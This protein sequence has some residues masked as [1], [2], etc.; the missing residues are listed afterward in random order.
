MTIN[1]MI[2]AIIFLFSILFFKRN[3][4]K[5]VI[6]TIITKGNN[7]SVTG[8]ICTFSE[9]IKIT[10]KIENRIGCMINGIFF[11]V[12]SSLIN[13]LRKIHFSIFGYIRTIL[14]FHQI[15]FPIGVFNN[16]VIKYSKILR[17]NFFKIFL[18]QII[19]YIF[20]IL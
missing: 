20:S 3:K 9:K 12:L 13:L 11:R 15:D 4:I 7:I 1:E 8:N 17:C 2:N 10:G 14:I 6:P 16:R 19:K 5:I 18:C